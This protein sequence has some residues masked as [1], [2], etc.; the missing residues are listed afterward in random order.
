MSSWSLFHVFKLDIS[1]SSV[2]FPIL[3]YCK[4]PDWKHGP[5]DLSH[6]CPLPF[7]ACPCRLSSFQILFFSEWAIALMAFGSCRV[8]NLHIKSICGARATRQGLLEMIFFSFQT[9][10][11][12][13]YCNGQTQQFVLL[14]EKS[15]FSRATAWLNF[16]QIILLNLCSTYSNSRFSSYTEC[17]RGETKPEFAAKEF[18]LMY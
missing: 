5:T 9:V 15:L 7:T 12:E 18:A 3:R 10:T 16:L 13:F 2:F 14:Y 17:C 4:S 8:L 11:S 6:I 1:L